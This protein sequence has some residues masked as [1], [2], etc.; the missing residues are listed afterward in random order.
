MCK[1]SKN[2]N[3]PIAS[4]THFNSKAMRI[5]RITPYYC[6]VN[7]CIIISLN[8]SYIFR[9]NALYLWGKYIVSFF[10]LYVCFVWFECAFCRVFLFFCV[11]FCLVTFRVYHAIYRC[12][13]LFCPIQSAL[14]ILVIY[15]E[16]NCRVGKE[17]RSFVASK[18]SFDWWSYSFLLIVAKSMNETSY[19]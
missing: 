6:S 9:I 12:N 3:T 10:F 7:F 19:S 11:L 18:D 2:A 16:L 14:L 8:C 15:C 4:F 5:V 1:R 13:K 17:M